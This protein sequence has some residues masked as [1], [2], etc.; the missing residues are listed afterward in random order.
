VFILQLAGVKDWRLHGSAGALPLP[1]TVEEQAVAPDQLGPPI[2]ECQLADGD[3]LYLPRGHVHEALTAAE[4]SLHLTV[5][6]HVTRWAD[7]LGAAIAEAAERDV[8]L[9]EAVPPDWLRGEAPAEAVRVRLQKLLGPIAAVP[10]GDVL[11]RWARQFVAARAG[12]R[13]ALPQPRPP[14]R[15]RSGHA[16]PTTGGPEL[17]G[18]RRERD[19][20]D[21]LW[22]YLGSRPRAHCSPAALR[23]RDGGLPDR[24]P[25]GAAGRQWES[26]PG[27]PAGAG[28][29]PARGPARREHAEP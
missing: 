23:R 19:C 15:P 18:R 9:R 11:A 6:L 28:R 8:A 29:A 2:A 25:A 1:G 22:R 12:R 26:G 5:G 7:L 17:H 4:S 27:P 16:G 14:G 10:E 20:D 24:R 13:G 21:P 3:L